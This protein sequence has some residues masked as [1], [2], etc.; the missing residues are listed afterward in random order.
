MVETRN[1]VGTPQWSRLRC[2][3]DSPDGWI[4]DGNSGF[5]L[6]TLFEGGNLK[7]ELLSISRSEGD[8]EV[9]T[10]V[11]RTSY[12][13]HLRFMEDKARVS[14]G[15]LEEDKVSGF[16]HYDGSLQFGVVDG[17]LL[18]ILPH[19]FGN[20]ATRIVVPTECIDFMRYLKDDLEQTSPKT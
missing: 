15:L 14:G 2:A 20:S 16:W 4:V 10:G 19:R 1:R 8:V 5:T 17:K 7:P 12:R 9:I 18:L 13:L 11:D 6:E 3:N